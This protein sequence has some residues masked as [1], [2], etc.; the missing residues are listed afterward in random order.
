[1]SAAES[2]QV[3]VAIDVKRLWRRLAGESGR[4]DFTPGALLTIC[5]DERLGIAYIHSPG[6]ATG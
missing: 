5:M 4:C 2:H 1:M 6:G 3:D